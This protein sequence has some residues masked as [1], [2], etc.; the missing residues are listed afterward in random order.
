MRRR[1]KRRRT[2]PKASSKTLRRSFLLPREIERSQAVARRLP[3]APCSSPRHPLRRNRLQILHFAPEDPEA[4]SPP[5]PTNTSDRVQ[6]LA[7]QG[8]TP[9]LA[10]RPSGWP[11]AALAVSREHECRP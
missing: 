3:P 5:A 4:S 10:A 9:T 8:A 11:V 6:P 1:R 7:A 2:A